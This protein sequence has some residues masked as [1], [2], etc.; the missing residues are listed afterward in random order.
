M[1]VVLHSWVASVFSQPLRMKISKPVTTLLFVTSAGN[2]SA[3]N[4]VVPD[5]PRQTTT[6]QMSSLCRNGQPGCD[7]SPQT[8]VRTGSSWSARC[9]HESTQKQNNYGFSTGTSMS[10]AMVSGA[11]ALVL[12]SCPFNT[13]GLKSAL[14]N[15]VDRLP[16]LAER[17]FGG[18]FERGRRHEFLPRR[19]FGF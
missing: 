11:A 7:V 18:R 14:I 15:N 19:H 9:G 10:A 5:Y 12:A 13:A 17:S 2:N 6:P 8:S 4:D 3:N 16:S 1:S